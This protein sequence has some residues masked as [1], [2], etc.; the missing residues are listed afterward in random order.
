MLSNVVLPQPEGPTMAT[1]SPSPTVKLMLSSAMTVLLCATGGATDSEPRWP[2]RFAARFLSGFLLQNGGGHPREQAWITDV[3]AYR[4]AILLCSKNNN[5]RTRTL[6]A[7]AI[8]GFALQQMLFMHF[9]E[10]DVRKGDG[11]EPLLSMA[12]PHQKKILGERHDA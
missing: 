12:S 7:G 3:S 8:I 6:R 2:D 1:N 5:H 11:A 10:E 9:A 4:D